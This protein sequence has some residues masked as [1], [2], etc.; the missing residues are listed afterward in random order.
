M[1]RDGLTRQI[2]RF[3]VT[4][5]A[6]LVV[7]LLLLAALVEFGGVPERYAAIVSTL[8]VLAGGFVLV[9]RWVFSTVSSS[10]GSGRVAK[11]GGGY[12]AVMVTGKLV[13]YGLYL[14][15]LEFRVW[16]PLAWFLGSAIVFAC[17]FSANKWLWESVFG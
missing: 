4:G 11:R 7:N 6:G 1:Q 15:F 17:T 12:Y 3:G 8:L 2:W 5:G 10:T 9:D 14:V 13:N 16:Y